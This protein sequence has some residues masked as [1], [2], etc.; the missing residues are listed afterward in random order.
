MIFILLQRKPQNQSFEK[1]AAD[2]HKWSCY[3]HQTLCIQREQVPLI[4]HYKYGDNIFFY[5]IF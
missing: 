1:R 5:H 2:G 4:F 3:N